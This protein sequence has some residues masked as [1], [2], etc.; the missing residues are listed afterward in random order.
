MTDPRLIAFEGVD[1]AGKTTVLSLVAERL[2][3]RGV[4]VFLPRAGKEHSS[5]P[6]RMIRRLTR[7]A[8]NFELSAEA[9]LLLYCARE[10][11]IVQE[12]IRPALARGETVLVDRS[13]LTPVVIG[14]FGRG[15]ERRFCESMARAASLDSWPDVTL[16]F[17][18]HPRTSRLRKRVEKV[19]SKATTSRGR[20]GL[21]GSAFKERIRDGYLQLGAEAGYPVFHA[22][23]ATP[24]VV[25]ERVVQFLDSGARPE[26]TET[27]LDRTPCWRIDSDSGFQAACDTLPPPVA[28]FLNNGL[29]AGR[30]LRERYS[31][32]EPELVSWSLDPLDPLRERFLESQPDYALRGLS[33]CPLG[34]APHSSQPD[35]RLA[36]L[37]NAP[38]PALRALRYVG[39]AEADALRERYAA[40]QPGAVLA[41]LSGRQDAAALNLRA[42]CWKDAELLDRVSSLVGCDDQDAWQRREKLFEKN[43]EQ[44]VATLRRVSGE[45]ADELL[46][47][48]APH[49]PKLVLGAIA[50]R[51]DE[52]ASRLRR[53]LVDTGRE[54]IESTAFVDDEAAWALRTELAERYPSTVIHSLRGLNDSPR[55]RELVARC[56]RLGSGDLH[57]ARRAVGLAEYGDLPAWCQIGSDTDS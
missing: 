6:T 20:K 55:R 33:R 31:E 26:A 3:Q 19:R 40:E 53:E 29:A 41:S 44:A 22:E 13:F 12:L 2:R 8:R 1:G 42:R 37:A 45:R 4:R 46:R 24:D 18:V 56:E 52:T 39:G 17:D 57:T 36:V 10:A 27:E 32:V 9:E 14:A 34:E 7:D 28:L 54:V 21:A 48:L 15:L 16:L 49:M 23:R 35:M 50:G 51:S 47:W 11:Q 38:G 43:P 30:A 25:A 5:Q